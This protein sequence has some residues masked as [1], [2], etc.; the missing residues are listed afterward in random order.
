MVEQLTH[1]GRVCRST[2]K[3]LRKVKPTCNSIHSCA[4]TLGCKLPHWLA[5]ETAWLDCAVSYFHTPSMSVNLSQMNPNVV[6]RV[7][8]SYNIYM[9]SCSCSVHKEPASRYADDVNGTGRTKVWVV[10]EVGC[11]AGLRAA[12]AFRSGLLVTRQHHHSLLAQARPHVVVQV[13]PLTHLKSSAC[14]CS[15][16]S[17]ARQDSPCMGVKLGLLYVCSGTST[18]TRLNTQLQPKVSV[19]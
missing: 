7:V 3:A 6:K 5:A 18:F 17:W 10:S 9:P 15:C 13:V 16:L 8:T 1:F 11:F 14:S 2:A 4:C 12:H 19:R